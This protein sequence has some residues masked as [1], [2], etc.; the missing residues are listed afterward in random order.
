MQPTASPAPDVSISQD[1]RH[2]ASVLSKF[3]EELPVILT[4]LLTAGAAIIIG[5]LLLRLF[6]RLLNKHLRYRPGH[7]APH[8]AAGGNAAVADWQRDELSDVLFHRAGGAAHLRGGFGLA[9]GRGRHRQH[10]PWLWRAIAGEGYHQ[11]HVPMDG[12]QHHCGRHCDAGQLHW[13][14]GGHVAAHHHPAR[15]RWHA[16]RHPQRR[17]PHRSLPFPAGQ[18]WRR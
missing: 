15:H 8:H 2:A 1:L 16:V 4:R 7:H 12:G 17:Y 10:C 6:R 5:L 3:Y 9:P 18:S 11:R 13:Q 14:G